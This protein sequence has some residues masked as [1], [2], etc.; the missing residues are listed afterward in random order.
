[1]ETA[2][3]FYKFLIW[4]PMQWT[5]ESVCSLVLLLLHCTPPPARVG[6]KTSGPLSLTC[7]QETG[8]RAFICNSFQSL[9]TT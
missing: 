8:F 3:S 7:R 5:K 1:M 9:K 4:V 2:D 6:G